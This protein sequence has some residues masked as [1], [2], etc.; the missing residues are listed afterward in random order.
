MKMKKAY[1]VGI[2]ACVL[3]LFIA[4][5]LSYLLISGMM[6]ERERLKRLPDAANSI[7]EKMKY[8]AVADT[9][10]TEKPGGGKVLALLSEGTD[11][12]ILAFAEGG[13]Y[14]VQLGN[15]CGFV[16]GDYIIDKALLDKYAE[17]K[18]VNMYVVNVEK[19]AR[20]YEYADISSTAIANASKGSQVTAYTGMS[21]NGFIHVMINNNM[22]GYIEE[23]YLSREAPIE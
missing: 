20:V 15:M 12:Q 9:Q 16:S 23:Q 11:I 18:K 13:Y 19:N 7:T 14:K 6:P 5:F 17:A 22:S 8:P 2:S 3:L 10:I 4:A 21:E 1:W